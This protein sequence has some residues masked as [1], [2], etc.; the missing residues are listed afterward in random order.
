MILNILEI[1]RLNIFF[2]QDGNDEFDLQEVVD[3]YSAK[4]A[5]GVCVCV[6]VFVCVLINKVFFWKI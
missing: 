2:A 5:R 6:C 3:V 4:F 1:F